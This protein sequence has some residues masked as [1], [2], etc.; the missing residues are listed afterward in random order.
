MAVYIVSYVIRE[1]GSELA[2]AEML[3]EKFNAL[4]FQEGS[5]ILSY[6]GSADEILAMHRS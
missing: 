6:A 2:M 4:Q 5:W 1:H 3:F